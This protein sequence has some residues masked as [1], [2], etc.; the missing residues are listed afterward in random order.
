MSS[1][2]V[3]DSVLSMFPGITKPTKSSLSPHDV[4]EVYLIP[5]E[6][7]PDVIGFLMLV[8]DGA[9][10]HHNANGTD[11]LLHRDC[12]GAIVW[13]SVSQWRFDAYEL[14]QVETDGDE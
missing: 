12:A 9:Y 13:K 14:L 6:I 4:Y 1:R 10:V 8:L 3:I 2:D 11:I 5:P 7:V